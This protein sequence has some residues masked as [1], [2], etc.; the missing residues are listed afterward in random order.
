MIIISYFEPFGKDAK[1]ST[2]V[3]CE[4]IKSVRKDIHFVKLPTVFFE[5][6]NILTKLIEEMRPDF[7]LMLGQAG[8]RA[9]ITPEKVALNWI[10]ARIEDN[11]GQKPQD[12][13][14]ID[15]GPVAYLSTL[16][17]RKITETLVKKGIPSR[18]SY[19]AGTFVC[20]ALFYQVMHFINENN[21]TTSAGFIHFPYL[22]GQA[23][24][25]GEIPSMEL[26]KSIDGLNTIVELL[27]G[28]L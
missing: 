23:L 25:N 17:V 15:K 1:N 14:I 11:K 26:E 8:G 19:T 16:P 13:K 12:T 3:I 18:I 21:Y 10:D 6:G 5:S 27:E 9:A 22:T 24:Y 20:N 7:V 2:E 28:R 4:E